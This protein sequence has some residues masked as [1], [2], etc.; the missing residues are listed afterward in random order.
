M[1]YSAGSLLNPQLCDQQSLKVYSIALSDPSTLFQPL[2][3]FYTEPQ[4]SAGVGFNTTTTSDGLQ[5]PS[6][7]DDESNI[8]VKHGENTTLN[9]SQHVMHMDDSSSVL[10]QKIIHSLYV[11]PGVRVTAYENNPVTTPL[12]TNNKFV[13]S[14]NTL[15]VD[16][17]YQNQ[18]LRGTRGYFFHYKE[19][20]NNQPTGFAL[21]FTYWYDQWVKTTNK[22]SVDDFNYEIAEICRNTNLRHIT[23]YW[24]VEIITP[25][26][27][28]LRE[29]C[30]TNKPLFIGNHDLRD[31]YYPQ[32]SACDQLMTEFCRLNPSD[33]SCKCFAQQLLLDNMF[34]QDLQ[35]SV[36]CFG[37]LVAT[38][39]TDSDKYKNS[40]AFNASAYKTNAMLQNTCQH[41]DCRQNN[42]DPNS[43][44]MICSPIPLDML[45]LFSDIKT[46]MDIL[47]TSAKSVYEEAKAK[48]IA[49]NFSNQPIEK[50]TTKKITVHETFS[51]K[52]R[53]GWIIIG[54]GILLCVLSFF[55]TL[56]YSAYYTST[57]GTDSLTLHNSRPPNIKNKT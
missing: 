19:N 36:L 34:S 40:C 47:N 54:I 51:E 49:T 25:F 29:T 24:V 27:Q 42:I 57:F 13:F 2:P 5:I 16:T 41:T 18:L 21:Q 39:T 35:I 14:P 10:Y 44:T 38:D 28:L 50:V 1:Y 43:G 33:A 30:L 17:C 4:C 46:K 12:A 55:I 53:I 32:S 7:V 6:F 11:P 56:I 22:P 31:Y 23:K 15:V 8:K 9:F 45:T 26:K 20:N 37:H 3:L 52:P 48:F